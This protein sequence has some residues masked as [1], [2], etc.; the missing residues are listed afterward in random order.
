MVCYH[1][2]KVA[3]IP[4]LSPCYCKSVQKSRMPVKVTIRGNNICGT[5]NI[6]RIFKGRIFKGSGYLHFLSIVVWS[7]FHASKYKYNALLICISN[8]Y[9]N[10]E[11]TRHDTKN[12]YSSTNIQSQQVL[13]GFSFSL[14]KLNLFWL[15]CTG[16][17]ILLVGVICSAIKIAKSIL[18][19]IYNCNEFEECYSNIESSQSK[20][21]S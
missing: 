2:E 16:R 12:N 11:Y 19:W 1:K 7:K 3:P 18:V 6:V 14:V 17:R 10:K 13:I 8:I 4:S 20:Q 9:L 15:N 5:F 21:D